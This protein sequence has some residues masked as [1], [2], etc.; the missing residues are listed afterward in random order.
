MPIFNPILVRKKGKTS[1]PLDPVEAYENTRPADWLPMPIPKA[2]EIYLLVHIPDG[3]S[4]LIAFT[5]GCTDDYTVSIGAT[6]ICASGTKFEHELFAENYSNL[7]S[8]GM[9]QCLLKVT[10]TDITSFA[11]ATHSLKSSPSDYNAWNIVEISASLPQSTS[12]MCKGLTAL[13]FFSLYGIN[14][15]TNMGSMFYNCY[16]LAIIPTLDTSKV[17][18]M[19]SMF[20]N[21]YSLTTIPALNTSRVANMGSMFYNCY[22]LATIPTLDTSKV[23]GMSKMFYNCYSLV[24]IPVLDTSK[25][26]GMGGMFFNCYSLASILL[27]P[28]ITGWAGYAIELKNASL[29]HQ[30]IINLLNSLPTI[31]SSKTLTLIGNPGAPELTNEEKS[32]ATNKHWALSL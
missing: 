2:N 23:T 1:V 13:K 32:I 25:V 8:T 16:S 30:A 10:G 22:S 4:S 5:V 17:T 26:T 27:K 14:N 31:T 28:D 18:G 15:I 3:A 12:I 7:T 24:A 20:Q 11:L 19:A 9:K 6:A 29:S 21:C